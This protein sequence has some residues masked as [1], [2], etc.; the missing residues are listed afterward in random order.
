MTRTTHNSRRSRTSCSIIALA[1][2]LAVGPTPAL[3]D[4]RSFHGAETFVTNGGGAA[5]VTHG[6]DLTTI[7]L[8][9]GNTIINWTPTDNATNNGV[10]ISFQNA[11]TTA[12]FTSTGNFAVL[13]NILP[14]DTSRAISMS[15]TVNGLVG[16]TQG[17]SIYFYSPSGFLI[18]N[19]AVFNVGS[20]AL[21][22]LPITNFANVGATGYG[23]LTFG[24]ALNPDAAIVM[25]GTIN[26]FI[27]PPVGFPGPGG[28]G[29][30]AM[31]AP[32]VVHN[33]EITAN[34]STALVAAEAATITFSTD[35]LFDISVT[36]GTD[37]RD[38][39]GDLHGVEVNG[40]IGGPT[41]TGSGD[42]QG[43][44]LV[45]VPKND[46]LTMVI[47][48]GAD[49]GFELAGSAVDD[50]GTIVLSAG[51][52]IDNGVIAGKS[53][54]HGAE[55]SAS[56]VFTGADAAN[57][58]FGRA[59]GFAELFADA[60]RPVTNFDN[61]VT[62][63][64]VEYI[65]MGAE[66]VENELTVGGNLSLSTD[67]A[68]GAGQSVIAGDIN[69]YASEGAS[70]SVSGSTILSAN[71][72]G[73]DAS[74][75]TA[76]SGSGGMIWVQENDGGTLALLSLTGT[77]W[78]TGGSGL[79]AG[80]NAGNGTG[81]S[82][83]L[84]ADD[85]GSATVN[86][87]LSFDAKG[88]GGSASGAGLAGN[89]LGGGAYVYIGDDA[90]IT[91][92][93]STALKSDGE[94]GYHAT[95]NGGSGTGGASRVTSV[96]DSISSGLIAFNGNV[97]ISSDGTG[98]AS[99]GA[100]T[101]GAGTGG[102]ARISTPDDHDVDLNGSANL[103]ANG[104][105][106]SSESG[107]GGFGDGGRAELESYI[108]GIDIS[109]SLALTANGLGG[110]T[111]TVG[112]TAGDG[113][114]GDVKIVANA[115]S[116]IALHGFVDGI[117]NGQGG[118]IDAGANGGDGT[119]GT[120][121]VNAD[122]GGAI[123]TFGQGA[124]L[125]AD[126]QG[127]LVN[128]DCSECSGIGGN[129]QG[130]SVTFT[131]ASGGNIGATGSMELSA[132]GDG[133][134][135]GSGV[136]GNGMGGTVLVQTPTGVTMS[137]NGDLS[138]D[139]AGGGG[140][141]EG[142]FAAGNGTGNSARLLVDGGSVTVTGEL[143]IDADGDGGE[144]H[145]G[146]DGGD[147]T[148]GLAVMSTSGLTAQLNVIG[149]VLIEADATGGDSFNFNEGPL[150]N[151]GDAFGGRTRAVANDGL[152]HVTGDLE[153]DAVST[154]GAGANGGNATGTTT[155]PVGEAGPPAA[156]VWAKSTDAEL[157]VDGLTDIDVSALGGAGSNG[158]GGT[159]AGGEI[160]IVV[161]RGH[162]NLDN[163]IGTTN[164]EGGSGSNGGAGGNATAGDID[165]A[166]SLTPD[167]LLDGTISMG[168][169]NL[170]ASGFGGS[171]GDGVNGDTGGA[172][173]AGGS[174]QGGFLFFMSTA[175][176]STLT[177]GASTLL[178]EGHGGAGGNGGSGDTGA[179]GNGGAGGS[180]SGGLVQ[181][182][183]SNLSG[184]PGTGGTLTYGALS[185]SASATGGAGG[186][187]G[188][189]G[190]GLGTGGRGGDAAGGLAGLTVR[191]VSATTGAVSL[192]ANA[193]G[194]NGGSG[195][196]SGNGGNA[197]TGNVVLEVKDRT[198]HPTQR[199]SLTAPSVTGTAIAVGGSGATPGTSTAI[200]NSYVR[201][202]NGDANIG[203]LSF[204]VSGNLYSDANGVDYIE[205]Q[206]GIGTIGS[207]TFDTDGELA[208]YTTSTGTLNIGG[209][210]AL[211]A[212]DFIDHPTLLGPVSPGN[213]NAA[214]LSVTSGGDFVADANFNI[215]N[216]IG[217]TV[218]GSIRFGNATTNSY[219]DLFAQGGSVN[220]G[221]LAATGD[222][223]VDAGSF[224][225]LGTLSG[226]DI[227]LNAVG[228][229][230][231]VSV[232]AGT[233]FDFDTENGSVTGGNVVAGNQISGS[234]G[235]N[236]V[237]Q[238]LS[239]SGAPQEGE[240]FSVGF[241]AIGNISVGNVSGAGPVGFAT[242]GN[243]VT[244][245]IGA[246]DLFMALV[247]GNVTTNAI[248]T[249]GEG[250]GQVYI[251]DDSMFL[252]GG[253]SWDGDG[254]FIVSSVLTE[255]PVATGGSITI[256]GAVNTGLFRVAAGTSL[257]T[258]A[259]TS[260]GSIGLDANGAITTGDLSAGDFVLANAGSITTG[261]IAA[262][263][264]DME[265]TAGNITVN[266][267]VSA[268]GAV[269]LDAFGNITTGDIDAASID[270]AAGGNITTDNLT[271][272]QPVLLSLSDGITTQ[273][274]PGASITLNAEGDIATD[275]I[276][277]ADGVYAAAGGS[278]TTGNIVAVDFVELL[279][280]GNILTNNIG[281]GEHVTLAAPGT[282]T[283]DN[284]NAGDAFVAFGHGDMLFGDVTASEVFLADF[285][286]FTPGGIIANCVGNCGTLGANGVVTA[287]PSGST[288]F[289]VTTEGGVGGVGQVPGFQGTNNAT[290]GSLYTTSPFS[291]DAGDAV[292]FWFN[293]VT[294]D[295][296]GFADYAWS[297]LF[298]AD[299]VPVAILYTARTQAEGTIVPGF[300]L[301]G[302][303]A[304]LDPAE[305]PIIPGGPE[306]S[307]LGTSSTSCFSAG[308]GYTGWVNS[309]YEIADSGTYVLG[310]GVTNWSDT[311]FQSGMAFSGITVGGDTVSGAIT[312]TGGSITMGNVTTNQLTAYAGTDFT[313]LAITGGD[314]DIQAGGTAT[315]NGAWTGSDI[316]V[317]SNDI[318]I[319]TNGSMDASDVLNLFSTNASQALIGDGLSGNGYALSDA[320]FGRIEGANVRI[321]GRGDA[322]AA[323]DMLI[324]DLTVTGP[325]MGSTISSSEGSLVFA[326]GDFTFDGGAEV[327]G[328]I[329]VNGDVEATGFGG[330]N[331]VEFHAD[332]FE[333]DAAT[334]SV[335]I[336]S[337]GTT[338]SGELGLYADRIHV[339]EGSILNQLATN[340]TY[341]GYQEDLN[342]AASVQR[343]GG[344][345]VADTLW[346]ESENLQDVLIQNTGSF[347]T[348]AGFLVR[349]AFV[350]EDFEVAG[351]PGSIN[352]VVNGQLV[353]EG[354]TLTGV[355]VRDALVTPED[356]ITPFTANST[357]NG[358]PLTGA[359]NI[360]PP[361]PPPT[362][363]VVDN[364]IDIITNDPLGD[365]DFGNE[366][367]IDDGEEGDEESR[368]NP[369][370]PPQPLFDT[371]PL[372]PGGDV[373]DPISGTGNPALL[374][375]E[376][377]SDQDDDEDE[378]DEENGDGE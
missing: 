99:G 262:D 61:D 135:G 333:L 136:A 306:W 180:G 168:T 165:V 44:Y 227:E 249:S 11:G 133:G 199:G 256:N 92:N 41:P 132:T 16:G 220:V 160:D 243:L 187:G 366:D 192:F 295:G 302:V 251:A 25:D 2:V 34:G 191:G 159:A 94:G 163:V 3:A 346:I 39:E 347:G 335:S 378:E 69:L 285:V 68:G 307:P 239:V 170:S 40:D 264:V 9:P 339:A 325:N 186:S 172:G 100:G 106:G 257:T 75:G 80:V 56:F 361:P 12:N 318:N 355:A 153:M 5:G 144:S 30:V 171:G 281:A 293:Y 298:T 141:S 45:A 292:E 147:G 155:P 79:A 326:V 211:A 372:I 63:Q 31:V 46:A 303:E 117:A 270:L 271:T 139:A 374:G 312:P 286:M 7:S 278:I 164:A 328:V 24:Q 252:T 142:S 108:G 202:F 125:F 276:D 332:R 122:G 189:G 150:G 73:G 95:G 205:V 263:S 123:I 342:E 22:A 313:A 362:S 315:V 311:G 289:F 97:E 14:Q 86:G 184:S 64:A 217:I 377:T 357:I 67:I 174:G 300:G 283:T 4:T 290:N 221:N 370:N 208:I 115:G 308:C 237:L 157:R 118:F 120:I 62:V 137:F 190:G 365:S 348:R 83:R 329:R 359:C 204:N 81:G 28:N 296:A 301:P 309:T 261:N 267:D 376:P 66:G 323:Q 223:S 317:A 158:N 351:P 47:T 320:E 58:L 314:I 60:D 268:F 231:F 353:T 78:G 194:G 254:D 138:L 103:H 169:V 131:G 234:A 181:T 128:G 327:S 232:N 74:S 299:L 126:G 149:D 183:T 1:T 212:R 27:P 344:V 195:S 10:A 287:P 173:G 259:I 215:T 129:G 238:N 33:G 248:T 213:I 319:T 98:G 17:G 230:A 373:N 225:S 304:T 258:G 224:M 193:T 55:A 294:S 284:V 196:T 343:P 112:M 166:Y 203:S 345:L 340:P 104:T 110:N 127:S 48:N 279:A 59:T 349:Q 20:L 371:R 233:E 218:P 152:I 57:D 23:S 43:I 32:R 178:V 228:D 321:L 360:A 272:E 87:A 182:G 36:V 38:S 161:E 291:A 310:F 273:L 140:F 207:F 19:S 89:G 210:L 119:G 51:H 107:N 90:T 266:G 214:S 255:D 37:A 356:D 375:S 316:N 242:Q 209:A 336:F 145:G 275:N 188:E 15:G 77:A 109:G 222:L 162:L 354:G 274:E 65:S 200:G 197:V 350:N 114:G 331:S 176:G 240:D 101:G 229:I 265:S 6:T 352:M 50:N 96:Q 124:N 105:G 198:G 341:T 146:G 322:S 245:T 277:S 226:S 177:A 167:A 324:G 88:T 250:G 179:G 143:N 18:G 363:N 236:V 148:G 52:D 85:T 288:Y 116:T 337:S 111:D 368:T 91:I 71:A 175:A 246:G 338:L 334:G 49:L 54:G 151:G 134:S 35:M 282:I 8:N 244:G 70:V 84:Y 206:D 72:T 29:Y 330:G 21:S 76:G 93:G 102:W 121:N 154:G 26:A 367:S 235:G 201:I 130:G 297:G 156:F 241:S 369:I 216:G 280:G 82:L 13:N 253:G 42:K 305:V 364:F 53:A 358:C 247:G 260:G 269:E 219:I 185:Q 113:L